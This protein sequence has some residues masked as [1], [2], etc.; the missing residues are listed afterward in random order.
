[1][2]WRVNWST[3]AENNLAEIWLEAVN[4]DEVTE[5]SDAMNRTLQHIPEKHLKSLSEGLY[6][7]DITPLRAY[8][9]IDFTQHVIYVAAIGR[10]H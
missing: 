7:L 5:A 9:E 2:Y 8:V 4:R 6:F 1:M 10:P 3:E